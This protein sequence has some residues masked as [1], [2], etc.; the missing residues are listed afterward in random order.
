MID[1][2]GDWGI[3]KTPILYDD[4][5]LSSGAK[6]VFHLFSLFFEILN[7]DLQRQDLVILGSVF[8]FQLLDLGL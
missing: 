5:L 4:L 8:S 3:P 1:V 6:V 2:M 7:T